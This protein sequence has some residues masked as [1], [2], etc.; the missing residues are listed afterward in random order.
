MKAVPGGVTIVMNIV[1]TV[2][3]GW[4]LDFPVEMIS[5]ICVL[6]TGFAGLLLILRLCMPFTLIRKILLGFLCALFAGCVVFLPG[7]FS[8]C[9]L[10]TSRCV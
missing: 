10:Y 7:L 3:I 5:T 2:F 1:L 8:L 4:K 6:L 9:L